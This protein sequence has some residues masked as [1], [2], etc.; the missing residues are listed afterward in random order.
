MILTT[1][2]FKGTDR[3]D[4]IQ[5]LSNPAMREYMH[6]QKREKLTHYCYRLQ[7]D[8]HSARMG[9]KLFLFLTEKTDLCFEIWVEFGLA[10][11]RAGRAS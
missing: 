3:D 10:E 8:P 7:T 1:H 6:R 11:S 9:S 2:K 5:A 4:M